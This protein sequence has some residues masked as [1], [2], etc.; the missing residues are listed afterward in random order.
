LPVTFPALIAN[1]T[2]LLERPVF[3]FNILVPPMG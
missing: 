2:K 1:M 3:W